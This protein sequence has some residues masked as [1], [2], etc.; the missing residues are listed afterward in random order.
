MS[1][2]AHTAKKYHQEAYLPTYVATCLERSAC[3]G[4]KTGVDGWMDAMLKMKM[5]YHFQ[6]LA[7]QVL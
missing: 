4:A 3:F 2:L 6:L 1:V 7:P 5:L